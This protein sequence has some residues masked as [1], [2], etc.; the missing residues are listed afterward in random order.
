MA[1]KCAAHSE[2]GTRLSRAANWLTFAGN[3]FRQRV[4]SVIDAFKAIR[5]DLE[6]E[7]RALTKH[8]SKR[9]KHIN[10]VI[11]SMAAMVGDVQAISGNAL[12]D[13][14]ALELE[15]GDEDCA[16]AQDAA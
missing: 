16:L 2:L 7:R 5:A 1:R 4:C 10:G 13:I 3:E 6:A 8:W 11:E 15:S 14:P 9:E 12:K